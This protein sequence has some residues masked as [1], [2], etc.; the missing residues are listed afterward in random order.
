MIDSGEDVGWVATSGAACS[1]QAVITIAR[2]KLEKAKPAFL[3][4][5][6]SMKHSPTLVGY[7]VRVGILI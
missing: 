3:Q 1:P 5:P 4:I 7:L 6:D 2:I